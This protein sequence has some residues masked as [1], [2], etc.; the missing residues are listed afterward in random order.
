MQYKANKGNLSSTFAL[1]FV[2]GA[3]ICIV[4]FLNSASQQFGFYH[5]NFWETNWQYACRF[6]HV[7][8]NRVL[9]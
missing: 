6:W 4:R 9:G 5:L 7:R 2:C 3:S 8:Y 1:R